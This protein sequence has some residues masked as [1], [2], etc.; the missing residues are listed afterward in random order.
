MVKFGFISFAALNCGKLIVKMTYAKT[1]PFKSTTEY[2]V[3]VSN[4]GGE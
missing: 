2:A 4:K 1:K 3:G